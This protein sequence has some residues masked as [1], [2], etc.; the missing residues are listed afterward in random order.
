MINKF[1][2][3][4][5][6][7]TFED[8][9]HFIRSCINDYCKDKNNLKILDVGCGDGSMTSKFLNGIQDKIH[10]V[11]GLDNMDK[12]GNNLIKYTKINLEEGKFPFNDNFFDIVYSNQ[13]IEHILNKD[14]YIS[15][16][17]RVL[18][19]GGLF[20]ISTE[21]ISSLDNIVS[22]ICG[23]EPLSQHTS[24][25]YMTGSFLSPHFMEKIEDENVLFLHKNVCSYYGLKRLAQINGFTKLKI[26]SF[27]NVFKLMEKIFPIYN[28][29]IVV[30]GI[31]Q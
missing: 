24:S 12:N 6:I 1:L 26:K 25:K 14:N 4:K 27:G 15:E 28:R 7:K 19:N 31:K 9:E 3:N 22:L 17:N 8:N 20:I 16:C 30:Y 29:L 18:K 10:E 13:V 11:Y 5:M 23:Q 21:N 2:I